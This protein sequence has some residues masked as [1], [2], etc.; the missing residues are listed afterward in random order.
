MEDY[1]D[2]STTCLRR[3]RNNDIIVIGTGCNSSMGCK[4][5]RKIDSPLGCFGLNH[6]NESGVRFLTY[7]AI[8]ILKVATTLRKNITQRGFIHEA[9][10]Y[11]RLTIL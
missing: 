11:V 8:N 2:K 7:L 6:T 3:K 1:F 9:R 4:S 5:G 10:T